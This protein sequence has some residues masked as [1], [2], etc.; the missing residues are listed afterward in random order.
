MA[1]Y[2][3]SHFCITR[4]VIF[5]K[6]LKKLNKLKYKIQV[7]LFFCLL[8]GSKYASFAQGDTYYNQLLLDYKIQTVL[9]YASE[10][11]HS[12]EEASVL[13]SIDAEVGALDTLYPLPLYFA[14]TI[15]NILIDSL[16]NR[17]KD[18]GDYSVEC[19]E[20]FEKTSMIAFVSIHQPHVLKRIGLRFQQLA[21]LHGVTVATV[22]FSTEFAQIAAIALLTNYG[23]GHYALLAPFI[24]LSFINTGLAIEIKN[25]N[26]H[27]KMRK[28]Y[29]GAK[30][31]KTASKVEKK[32]RK[33]M[34]LHTKQGVFHVFPS[35]DKQEPN[36]QYIISFK[37]KLLP[38]IFGGLRF[39]PDYLYWRKLKRWAKA[40]DTSAVKF[41]QIVDSDKIDKQ[42]RC[43]LYM[44]YLHKYDRRLWELYKQEQPEIV[45]PFILQKPMSD[46]ALMD[47][48]LWVYK[49][50]LANDLSEMSGFIDSI[51]GSLSIRQ[52]LDLFEKIIL[53]YWAVHMKRPGFVDFR[54]V[55]KGHK[56]FKYKSLLKANQMWD[57]NSSKLLKTLLSLEQAEDGV[58]F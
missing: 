18:S 45:K 35:A 19:R 52:V 50:L 3:D 27:R 10:V 37:P 26:H 57:A 2:T 53:P 16:L 1:I 49:G 12:L 9:T 28:G 47:A 58:D 31:K 20:V 56:A 43:V 4:S 55:V 5:F 29:G 11:T 34:G 21:R 54:K 41:W 17:A 32:K 48:K 51:P 39:K 38:I 40:N 13:L 25:I 22:W 33:E 42:L 30:I 7:V 23:L 46:F 44:D 8:F 15:A 14:E 6:Y 24:P 36:G